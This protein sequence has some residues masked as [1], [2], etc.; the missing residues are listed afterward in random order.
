MSWVLIHFL[1][2]NFYT[3]EK[4]GVFQT[5]FF[6]GCEIRFVLPGRAALYHVGGEVL[7]A[8]GDA[9]I[10]FPNFINTTVHRP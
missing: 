9:P 5:K 1:D 7:G 8:G 3:L 2:Y 4:K 6:S 10:E